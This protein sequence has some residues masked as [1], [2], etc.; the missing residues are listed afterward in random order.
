MKL[1][2]LCVLMVLLAA[3]GSVWAQRMIPQNM[4]VATLKSVA[5]PQVVLAND[6]WSWMRILTAGWLD[7]SKVYTLAPGVR[8]RNQQ[9][10][11]EV[12]SRLPSYNGQAVAIRFD[13]NNNIDEL[14]ILTAEEREVLR[15]RAKGMETRR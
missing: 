8:V 14:W 10:L 7:G 11:F 1:F 4:R 15:M 9:N 6:G 2:R 13:Q 5:Y 12:Y 3:S